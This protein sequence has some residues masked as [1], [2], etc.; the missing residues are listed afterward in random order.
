MKMLGLAEHFLAFFRNKF[1]KFSN[2]GVQMVD[3]GAQWLSW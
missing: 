3:S 2:T 1:N